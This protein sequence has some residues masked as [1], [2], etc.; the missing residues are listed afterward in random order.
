MR[1]VYLLTQ[2]FFWVS[3]A[4]I[5]Y[6]YFVYPVLLLFCYAFVQLRSDLGYLLGRRD[7]RVS[8][9]RGEELP[10]VTFLI[11][12]Y[13][14]EKHLRQKIANLF[15]MDYPR[16]K[17]QI[18]F[19]SDGSTDAT[20]EILAPLSDSGIEL[21]ALSERAGKANALNQGVL[22]A[23]HELLIFSDAST[24]F[25]PDAVQ[26]L[27]RHFSDE[28]VGVV[29]GALR[30]QAGAESQQTE[31]VYWRYESMMRLMEARLG[32][33]LTASG[34]VYALRR[35][36]YV[37]LTPGAVLDDFL[38]PMN[39]RRHCYRVLYD[40]EAVATDFAAENVQGEFT[41]RVRLAVG[42]FQSFGHLLRT[43]MDAFTRFAFL[44]HK[45]LRWVLP[46][47][48][49]TALVSNLILIR[50]SSMFTILGILQFAFYLWAWIGYL[51]QKRITRVRYALL[52]Y[53]ILAMNLAFLVGF[54]R[55]VTNRG[56]ATWQR[57]N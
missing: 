40:P 13:N 9:L 26:S 2:L 33:T 11:P 38:I 45:A 6:A 35:D 12:A 16:E 4:L 1:M 57:V 51:L 50:Y 18:I 55:Y 48:L 25:A 44:S 7:R 15:E 47:L 54:F 28:T 17:L 39:A 23:R 22:R 10:S 37:P 52:G 43:P 41:R 32:A 49:C 56:E 14:E 53:F 8:A 27:V 46:L 34:A 21:L 42:S 19:I 29:C 5:L 30:F 3:G 31:G 24:L 36:A 20:N